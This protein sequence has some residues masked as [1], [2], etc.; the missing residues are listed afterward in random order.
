MTKEQFISDVE[1]QVYQGQISDDAELSKDQ[2]AF[3]GSYNL[4]M[5]VANE[6]NEKLKR[7]EFFPPVYKKRA[8]CE[9]LTKEDIDCGDDCQD[10]VFAQLDEEILSLN[11][12]AG[13]MRVTTDE[14]DIVLKASVETLDLLRYMPFAKP[15]TDN[16]V[17]VREGKKIFIE[18]LK[19]VDIPF[20]EINVD[21]IPKQNLL[22]MANTDEVLV[23]DMALP[24]VIDLTVQRA[25]LELYGTQPDKENDG[26]DYKQTAYHTAIANPA[27]SE[28]Q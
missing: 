7:G 27:N 19:S 14:G 6:L 26:V 24:Q 22:T 21:Y 13:V 10:R 23:S 3:W 25:K 15:T 17:Y 18:G 20:N 2:I 8:S 28:P 5:V 9:V 4:N 11:K 12:D 16:L 1:L